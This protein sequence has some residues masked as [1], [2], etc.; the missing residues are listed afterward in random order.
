MTEFKNNDQGGAIYVVATPIGNLQDFTPRAKQV[1]ASVDLIA[2]E[3]TRHSQALLNAFNIHTPMISYHEHNE[4]AKTKHLLEKVR[5]GQSIAM[6]SDAGTPLISDPGYRLIQLAHQ[7]KLKVVPVPGCSAAITA[8]C[9]AGIPS[10]KFLFLGFLSAKSSA[11]LKELTQYSTYPVT[12]I[13]YESCHRILS[14]LEDL[15]SVMPERLL[16]LARELTKIHETLLYGPVTEIYNRVLHD[17]DQVKGEFVLILAPAVN[18]EPSQKVE[19]EAKVLLTALLEELPLKKAV[20]LAAKITGQRK[21][22]L[23]E[24]ALGK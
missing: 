4:E 13:I 8:L 17:A 12:L 16:M 20:M 22:Y 19:V 10:D 14:T 11:R 6:I 21:N 1:L 5:Q 2:A 9:A 23:Y 24:L 7:Q 3:D 15:A 18:Q